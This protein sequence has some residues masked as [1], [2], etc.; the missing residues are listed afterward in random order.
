LVFRKPP[1][2]NIKTMEKTRLITIVIVASVLFMASCRQKAKPDSGTKGQEDFP[3]EIV[4]FTP[5]EQN[6]VFKGT[7]QET[8]DKMI[9]ERGFILIDNGIY[10]MWYTGYNGADTVT[11]YLGYA[12]S[13]D[14]INWTRYVGNPVFNKRWTEDMFVF[15]LENKFYMFAEGRKDIAHLLISDDGINWED[16]GDLKIITTKGDTVPGPYGTPSILIENG[17]WHLFYERNDEGVWI[18]ESDDHLNWTNIQDEPV[19]KKGPGNYDSGAVANNQVVR[20]N[21]KFY[22]YY[23][24]TS[25]AGWSDPGASSIWTSNVAM[26]EDL[27][28]WIKYPKNPVVEGDHS[29]PVMVFNG[30]KYRLYTMHP[31]VW[32]YFS[33]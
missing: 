20:F 19:L 14:G 29:S 3:K 25:D 13:P 22:M 32:L 17:K 4:G 31:E 33:E 9:R 10:K 1:L 28:H 24:G 2:L 5:Y 26:S 21:G 18:A 8:W 16:Q 6:P 12:T 7:G 30:E 11:K 27:I 15:K 23:H